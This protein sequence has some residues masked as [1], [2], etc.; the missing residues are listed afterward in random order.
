MAIPLDSAEGTHMKIRKS[1]LSVAGVLLSLSS[2]VLSGIDQSPAG[3][4]SSS[5]FCANYTHAANVSTLK[6]MRAAIPLL[7]KL[8]SEAPNALKSEFK[9]FVV[10]VQ[11][12][13]NNNGTFSIQ[14]EANVLRKAGHQARQSG[15]QALQIE[16]I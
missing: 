13:T 10:S 12:L 11:Q 7:K 9:R 16:Q 8:E 1:T 15:R 2:V 4:A 3:A 14:G 5:K 6:Q